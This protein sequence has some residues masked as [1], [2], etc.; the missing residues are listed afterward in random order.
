MK[1]L[2]IMGSPRK[3]DTYR[4]CKA[5]EEKT[6][7]AEPVQFQYVFLKEKELEYCRGCMACIMKGKHFC[8][9]KDPVSSIWDEMQEADGVIFSSPVYAHQVTALMKNFIDR[10]AFLYHR[11]RFFDHAALTVATTATSGLKDVTDYLTLTARG[12]GFNLVGSLGI[13]MVAFEVSPKYKFAIM[14]E[15]D[16]LSKNFLDAMKSHKRPSPSLFDLIF[17]GAMKQKAIF[18]DRDY[19]FWLEQGWLDKDYFLDLPINPFKKFIARSWSSLSAMIFR[20]K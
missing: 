11:P 1:V 17:F 8:P 18:I 20:F 15:V 13:T 2:V 19:E 3:M 9:I 14:M 5:I 10:S 6:N 12:W 7:E 16:E 4:I